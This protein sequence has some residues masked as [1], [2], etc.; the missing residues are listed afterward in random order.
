M[1][2][3]LPYLSEI[4][5]L[6][7]LLADVHFTKGGSEWTENLIIVGYKL[8]SLTAGYT[9]DGGVVTEPRAW[10]IAFHPCILTEEWALSADGKLFPEQSK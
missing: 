7:G 3:H 4:K 2:F 8:L 1:L 6:E 10:T 9:R 5:S